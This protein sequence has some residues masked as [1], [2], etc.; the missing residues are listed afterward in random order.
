MKRTVGF[1]C[2][3][4]LATLTVCCRKKVTNIYEAEEAPV[5]APTSEPDKCVEPTPVPGEKCEVSDENMLC[6]G[7]FENSYYNGTNYASL[8]D[9]QLECWETKQGVEVQY[10]G[11]TAQAV[12]GEY[13]VELDTSNK[14]VQICQTVQTVAGKIYDLSFWYYSR[15]ASSSSNMTVRVYL[16]E[17]EVSASYGR[18]FSAFEQFGFQFAADDDQVKVCFIGSGKKD[19]QGAIIDDVVLKESTLNCEAK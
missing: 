17:S 6:N 15:T 9:G 3:L 2:F 11:H 19:G 1:I 5:P 10:S 12:E 8:V 7:S 16:R 18:L 14:N 13:V 4:M